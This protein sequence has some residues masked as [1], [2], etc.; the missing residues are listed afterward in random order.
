MDRAKQGGGF[1]AFHRYSALLLTVTLA[2]H[3]AAVSSAEC[4]QRLHLHV[5]S[6]QL[7]TKPEAEQALTPWYFIQICTFSQLQAYTVCS[8]ACT[9]CTIT[10]MNTYFIILRKTLDIVFNIIGGQQHGSNSP[11]SCATHTLPEMIGNQIIYVSSVWVAS[12]SLYNF[13]A[14]DGVGSATSQWLRRV[15]GAEWYCSTTTECWYL[16]LLLHLHMLARYMLS[17]DYQCAT[18]FI[19]SSDKHMGLLI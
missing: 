3:E 19:A 13:P 14:R 7:F 9:K 5:L 11:R 16:L 6:F 2:I 8:S 1:A 18:A 4:G 17:Y 15:A 10:A 12:R